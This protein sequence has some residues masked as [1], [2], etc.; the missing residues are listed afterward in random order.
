MD[1]GDPRVEQDDRDDG[2]GTQA[3]DVPAVPGPAVPRRG[4]A[5]RGPGRGGG[6]VQVRAVGDRS[7]HRAEPSRAR[8]PSLTPGHCSAVTENI[9]VSRTVPSARRW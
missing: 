3:L 7:G 8:S 2:D 6:A 1:A 5:G 4:R 9:T